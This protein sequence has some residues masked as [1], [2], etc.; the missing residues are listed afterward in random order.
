MLRCELARKIQKDRRM[1]V[2]KS[3]EAF[4]QLSPYAKGYVVYMLGA[5]NDEPHVPERYKPAKYN[6]KEYNHGQNAA[7]LNVQEGGG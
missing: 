7:V 5:R 2:I 3:V 4:A 6:R 1:S